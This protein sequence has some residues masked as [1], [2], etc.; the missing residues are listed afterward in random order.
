[1]FVEGRKVTT[2]KGADVADQFK[3]MVAD[4][5]ENRFGRGRDKPAAE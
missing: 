2:L 1:M 5:I 4:Y 3:A